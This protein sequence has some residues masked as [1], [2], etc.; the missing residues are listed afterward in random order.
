[1]SLKVRL[2]TLVPIL[3]SGSA[4]AARPVEAHAMSRTRLPRSV[5][6][7][8]V[9]RVLLPG[10]GC[11]EVRA[12]LLLPIRAAEIPKDL[13]LKGLVPESVSV[14]L[15]LVDLVLALAKS[16]HQIGAIG[17]DKASRLEV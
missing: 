7:P 11:A 5:W 16:S 9:I 13:W 6:R 10:N 12:L 14:V 15:K 1:M 8:R 2:L 4:G 3:T 17:G